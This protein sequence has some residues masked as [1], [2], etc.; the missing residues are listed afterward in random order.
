MTT[1][2]FLDIGKKILNLK[3]DFQE[4]KMHQILMGLTKDFVH[5]DF[6]EYRKERSWTKYDASTQSERLIMIL[7]EIKEHKNGYSEGEYE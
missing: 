6:I 3:M 4:K 1:V 7:K 5:K 2:N